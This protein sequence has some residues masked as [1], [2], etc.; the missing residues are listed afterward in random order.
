MPTLIVVAVD[1]QYFDRSGLS[2]DEKVEGR[3]TLKR[4][5][6][7]VFDKKIDEKGVDAVMTHVADRRTTV[8]RSYGNVLAMPT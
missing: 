6:R 7:G 5:A 2:N 4:F 1:K 3:L 8:I